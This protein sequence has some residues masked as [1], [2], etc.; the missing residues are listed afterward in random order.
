MPSDQEQQA[1]PAIEIT[2]V[3]ADVGLLVVCGDWLHAGF[4]GRS[5]Q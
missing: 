4:L 1:V 3:E 2:A 5:R